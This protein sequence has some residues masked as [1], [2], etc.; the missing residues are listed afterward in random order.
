MLGNKNNSHLN[1]A[2]IFLFIQL[3]VQKLQPSFTITTKSLL[4]ALKMPLAHQLS[5]LGINSLQNL[6]IWASSVVLSHNIQYI[7]Y[8]WSEICSCML[9]IR[10]KYIVYNI[11]YEKTLETKK[12]M[13]IQ[14]IQK[15]WVQQ[16]CA[17]KPL[18]MSLVWYG[19]LS[20]KQICPH[21]YIHSLILS[22]PATNM[23]YPGQVRGRDRGNFNGSPWIRTSEIDGT[24]L[25]EKVCG[26]RKGEG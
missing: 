1:N 17:W 24:S 3:K 10:I 7:Q 14:S 2:A 26:E 9:K 4:L 11:P 19:P 22:F 12:K 18:Y 6:C 20:D 23:M 5:V 21:S 8:L 25:G 15:H 13:W 16:N